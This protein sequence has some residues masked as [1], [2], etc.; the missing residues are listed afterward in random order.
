VLRKGRVAPM[1][2][3]VWPRPGEWLDAG[4]R[5]ALC[6]AG[7][8]AL[9]PRALPTWISE[10]LWWVEVDGAQEVAPGILAG[11]RGR[12]LEPVAAWTDQTARAFAQAAAA[13]V[14]GL[15]AGVA[16]RRAGAAAAAACSARADTSVTA[17]AYMA[18][19]A[20]ES[21]QEGGF[22]AERAWQA[23]WLGGRLGLPGA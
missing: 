18:A 13:H 23:E 3:V 11:P 15:R 2:G 4:E 20:R 6:R 5:I 8:H 21:A 16:G 22:A 1:T 10:E 9:L 17:V 19:Q 12:L 14:A 7:V